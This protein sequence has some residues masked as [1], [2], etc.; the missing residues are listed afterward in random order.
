MLMN[1]FSKEIQNHLLM[2]GI[3]SF[4]LYIFSLL[5]YF[6]SIAPFIGLAFDLSII[7]LAL[8]FN[9]IGKIMENRISSWK[10]VSFSLIG[11]SILDFVNI[12]L[13][14][15]YNKKTVWVIVGFQVYRLITGLIYYI[16]VI[17]SFFKLYKLQKELYTEQVSPVVP[18]LFLVYGYSIASVG[19][20]FLWTSE[21]LI[22]DLVS[23]PHWLADVASYILFVSNFIVILGFMNLVYFFYSIGKPKVEYYNQQEDYLEDD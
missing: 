21:F 11:V 15:L 2:S 3:A 12:I 6:A 4:L 14:L 23:R 20:V 18:R 16:F 5:F 17:L 1:N 13:Y 8:G 10:L 7:F 19:Y 9:R 22:S